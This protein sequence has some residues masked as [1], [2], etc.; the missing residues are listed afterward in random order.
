MLSVSSFL[1]GST[2]QPILGLKYS[3]GERMKESVEARLPAY[4]VKALWRRGG[5]AKRSSFILRIRP[6]VINEP[7]TPQAAK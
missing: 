5:E 6:E 7:P 3:R 1:P 2:G 4:Y